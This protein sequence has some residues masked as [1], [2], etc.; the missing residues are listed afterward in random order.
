MISAAISPSPIISTE[1]IT[2]LILAF[3]IEDYLTEL[4]K[5]DTGQANPADGAASRWQL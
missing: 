5:K 3:I 2:G 4:T 1:N